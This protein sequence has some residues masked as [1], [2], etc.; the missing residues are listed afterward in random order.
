MATTT[1]KG[2]KIPGD[3]EEADV[4][5]IVKDSVKNTERGMKA[6]PKTE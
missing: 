3:A 1:E 6:I 5:G 4:P 2:F